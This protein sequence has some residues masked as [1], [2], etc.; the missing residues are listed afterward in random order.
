MTDERKILLQGLEG[1][2]AEAR[3][4]SVMRLANWPSEV[5]I[6][7]I[8]RALGDVN[9]RVRKEAVKV[10]AGLAKESP[11]IVPH[12]ISA[13]ADEENIGLRNAALKAL[14]DSGPKVIAQVREHFPDLYMVTFKYQEN[15]S[16]EQL[17]A[18]A[19]QR[20]Q[21]G[22]QAVV[23]NRGEEQGANGEQIAYLVTKTASPQK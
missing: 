8:L 19:Q 15:I 2:N 10:A 20:L 21:Q 23:A 11:E 12:L 22:Y 13:T 14:V 1:D 3:R 7:W 16:H 4:R 5:R 6:E 9:W 18:I 17:I